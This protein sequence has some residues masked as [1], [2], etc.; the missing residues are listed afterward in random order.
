[1]L[2]DQ[3]FAC[4]RPPRCV[5]TIIIS[6]SQMRKPLI[7]RKRRERINNCLDQLKGT[8]IGAFKLDVSISI[9]PRVTHLHV[10]RLNLLYIRARLSTAIQAG[11]GRYSGD[12]S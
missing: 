12:D 11:E 2:L 4:R 6:P 5:I 3:A 8:V 7:E 10:N 1:M 9:H